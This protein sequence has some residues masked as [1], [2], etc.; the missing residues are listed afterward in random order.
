MLSGTL[1]KQRLV[2]L[3]QVAQVVPE[4]V[5]KTPTNKIVPHLITQK[6]VPHRKKTHRLK[7]LK[8]LWCLQ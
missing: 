4:A 7:T 6:V 3:V 8:N 1:G 5:V 2:T